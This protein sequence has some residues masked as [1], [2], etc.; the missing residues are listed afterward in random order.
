MGPTFIPQKD[1]PSSGTW[2]VGLRP[3]RGARGCYLLGQCCLTVAVPPPSFPPGK[4]VSPPLLVLVSIWYPYIISAPEWRTRDAL[5]T[6]RSGRKCTVTSYGPHKAARPRWFRRAR[7]RGATA[8]TRFAPCRSG[9]APSPIDGSLRG[10]PVSRHLKSST[11]PVQSFQ[12]RGVRDSLRSSFSSPRKVS[13]RRQVRA[14]PSDCSALL[15]QATLAGQSAG[16]SASAAAS[17]KPRATR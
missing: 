1:Y 17:P 16:L 11:L 6:S 7:R 14:A 8:A 5:P 3:R 4:A 9:S 12:S 10:Y 13:F 15:R 2:P